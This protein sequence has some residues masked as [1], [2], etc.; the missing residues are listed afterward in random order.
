MEILYIPQLSMYDKKT[1]KLTPE[2]D[3][4]LN[5]M[6]NFINEWHKYKPNDNFNI[7]LPSEIM[8]WPDRI[9]GN[10]KRLYYKD[11]VIS[12]RINRFNFP[13]KEIS[14]LIEC[15]EKPELIITDVIELVGNIKAMFKVNFGYIPKIISNIR[16]VDE[17]INYDYIWRVID[18][19]DNSNYCT[20]LSESM[21]GLL[22]EQL[23]DCLPFHMIESFKE[24]LE[25]FEP[26]VSKDELFKDLEGYKIDD[27]KKIIT[28]PGRLSK[29]EE[30][31][32]NY[33]KFIEAINKLREIRQDFEVYF[34]D[35]NNSI[36]PHFIKTRDWIKTINK[37]R[38]EFKNLLNKTDIIVSLMNIQ[39]F[40]GISIREALQYGCLPILPYVHEY[41]RMQANDFPGFIKGELTIESLVEKLNWALDNCW[42]EDFNRMKYAEQFT[43]ESQMK[44]LI[45]K[46]EVI[47]NDKA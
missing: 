41:K 27:S 37:D 7:L 38:K 46:L 31:R 23:E 24:K 3:G 5:M 15:I 10:K 35:P 6:Q 4:N 30:S 29:G 1:G 36:N 28:F 39:G 26:S 16:H 40:G 33:D 25:V 42:E 12:S 45:T 17:N 43:I 20:I 13:M 44:N 2:A 34:T 47:I 14:N 11:Y 9:K 19:I 21:R 18:G 8:W 32:T 22:L